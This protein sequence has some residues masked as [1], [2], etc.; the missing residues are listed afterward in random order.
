[1]FEASL[2]MIFKLEGLSAPL[3]LIIA[4]GIVALI[5]SFLDHLLLILLTCK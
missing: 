2:S 1:M 4:L 3:L 5:V